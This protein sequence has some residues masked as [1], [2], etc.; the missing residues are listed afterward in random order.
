ARGGG[1]LLTR[2]ARTRVAD[3]GRVFRR[4][5][6]HGG[7]GRH[8]ESAARPPAAASASSAR[9]PPPVEPVAAAPRPPPRGHLEPPAEAA[10][11]AGAFV[12]PRCLG[13]PVAL[14]LPRQ[15]GA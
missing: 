15:I 11:I 4:P 6:P 9:T 10:A 13:G 2:G 12:H 14:R 5:W 8:R 3:L 1:L 7:S